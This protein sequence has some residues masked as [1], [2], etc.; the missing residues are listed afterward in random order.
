M[1]LRS[2]TVKSISKQSGLLPSFFALAGLDGFVDR[3]IHV[4]DTREGPGTQYQAMGT[5]DDFGNRILQASGKSTNIEFV[6]QLEKLGGNGPIMANALVQ[7]G[8]KLQYIGSLGVPDIHPVFHQFAENTEAVSLCNPGVTHA[9]EFRDGKLLLGEMASLDEITYDKLLQT[10]GKEKLTQIISRA[11]L[12]SLVNWTMIP[13]MSAVFSD[14]IEKVLPNV[15]PNPERIFFFDLADP[16]KRSIGDLEGALTQIQRFTRF[17][18]VTLGLNFKESQ[19]VYSALIGSPPG[20]TPEELKQIAGEIQKKLKL[21]T[22]LVHPTSGAAAAN[23]EGAWYVEGPY[24]HSPKITTG[25][26]DH[27]NAGY[28][29]GQLLKL[30]PAESLTMAV[31]T[32]GYYVREGLSPSLLQLQDFISRWEN[33]KL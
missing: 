13:H 31:S 18:H 1:S 28:T 12:I 15:T 24:C 14:L 32:S 29:L 23:E 25:A 4:V 16:Q 27:F 22:V 11:N 10:V 30:S 2:N 6:P 7:A 33:G 17:G 21:G 5:I 19:Q 20:D 8:V 3:I 9:I 26:G